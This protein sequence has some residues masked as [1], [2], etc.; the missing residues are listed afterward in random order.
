[1]DE[2]QCNGGRV[3]RGAVFILRKET[4]LDFWYRQH[5]AHK[6]NSLQTVYCLLPAVLERQDQNYLST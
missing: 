6:G 1:M 3:I 4:F 5:E 2:T